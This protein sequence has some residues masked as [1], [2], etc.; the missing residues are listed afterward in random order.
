MHP[1]PQ[2]FDVTFD[3][4]IRLTTTASDAD[5]AWAHTHDTVLAALS[6]LS[7]AGRIA[8]DIHRGHIQ[9][10]ADRTDTAR[11]AQY[12]VTGT[13][14]VRVAAKATDAP[15]ACRRVR[16]LLR[17]A[18]AAVAPG[19]V[20]IDVDGIHQHAVDRCDIPLDPDTD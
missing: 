15:S 8:T 9:R 3:I 5:Q 7:V 2:G 16:H 20:D 10:L 18:L 12:T 1:L 6:T 4:P 19:E 11:Q 13:A 14:T 17:D